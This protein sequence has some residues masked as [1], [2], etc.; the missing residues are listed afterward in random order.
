MRFFRIFV[1]IFSA[2]TIFAGNSIFAQSANFKTGKALEV[3]YNILRELNAGFVDTIDTEKLINKG[4]SAM[5]NSLDPYTEYIPDE[6]EEDLEMMRTASYG[7]IGAMI[8][9]I[10]SIGVL[11]SQPYIGSPAVKYGLEPGDFILAIDGESVLPLPVDKCSEKMKGQPGT[12]VKF[13]VLKGRSGEKK[14]IVVT[15]ERVHIPDVSYS[16]VLRDS[17]GY[18][19]HDAFT[20][21]GS[22]D[23]R[24]AFE[25]LKEKGI[26]HLV[27]DLRSNGG[28]I[29]DEA[30]NILSLF[31]PKGT[32]V[33][34]AKGRSAQSVFEM[35]TLTEP[36]DTL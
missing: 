26:K 12:E 35:K 5:L 36:L 14:E 7:G 13:L 6:N 21:D 31:L 8:R 23:F 22:R 29:V 19:R 24:K 4:I 11:I 34:S 18:I 27:M 16:G 28:G 9:K 30:V 32:S 1:W 10:D 25:G 3:Q 20:Q 33:V 2:A 15:R 17:I